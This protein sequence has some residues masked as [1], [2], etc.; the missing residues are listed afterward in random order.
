MAAGLKVDLSYGCVNLKKFHWNF[1]LKNFS[2][3]TD[4]HF[5]LLRM[6]LDF[7]LSLNQDKS[8]FEGAVEVGSIRT[9]ASC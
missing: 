1:W 9:G 7:V 8:F 4:P 2:R 3:A 5:Y 6:C